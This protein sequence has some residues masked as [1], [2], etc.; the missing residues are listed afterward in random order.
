MTSAMLK[1]SGRLTTGVRVIICR[2]L[3]WFVPAFVVLFAASCGHAAD[4]RSSELRPGPLQPEEYFSLFPFHISWTHSLDI[5][6]DRDEGKYRDA[7][8]TLKE[9]GIDALSDDELRLV[10]IITWY[11]QVMQER[12]IRYELVESDSS[13]VIRVEELEQTYK[14]EPFPA[15][16][17]GRELYRQAPPTGYGLEGGPYPDEVIGFY[18]ELNG[19]EEAVVTQWER[20]AQQ[21]TCA[22]GEATAVYLWALM[23]HLSINTNFLNA[24]AVGPDTVN[25]RPAYKL[26]A[27]PGSS[28]SQWG[29]KPRFYWIDAETLLLV[30]EEIVPENSNTLVVT[31]LEL[32]PD[33]QIDPPDVDITCAEKSFDP[34]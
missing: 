23:G 27:P 26:E 13:G 18:E 7:V 31:T 11:A 25:G 33:I 1:P 22:R 30:R 15:L 24:Q 14:L 28:W 3:L 19:G 17:A 29:G 8:Q 16:V 20:R 10:L 5:V 34:Y 6:R 12:S 21:W 9:N 2:C 32:N 4:S